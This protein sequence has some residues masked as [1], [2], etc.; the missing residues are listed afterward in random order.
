[1]AVTIH[2]LD[3]L[4]SVMILPRDYDSDAIFFSSLPIYPAAPTHH[5]LLLPIL[6]P[7]HLLVP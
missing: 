4:Q 6:F 1:M 5:R 2:P 7:F 3:H